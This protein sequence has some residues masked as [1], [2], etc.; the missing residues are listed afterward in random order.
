V[1][2]HRGL[3]NAAQHMVFKN[4][5]AL[6]LPCRLVARKIRARAALARARNA[7]AAVPLMLKRASPPQPL[8]KG[9]QWQSIQNHA[10]VWIG[11]PPLCSCALVKLCF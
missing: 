8:P 11:V 5:G 6:Y 10:R 7:A 3:G 2:E 1:N 9:Q 4:R